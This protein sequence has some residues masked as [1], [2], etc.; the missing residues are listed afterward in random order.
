M[1]LGW[2][3]IV[4][5]AAVAS[6]GGDS[7]AT[8]VSPTPL[9]PAATAASAPAPAPAAAPAP[10]PTGFAIGLPIEPADSA[11]SAFG[12]APFGY[13]GGG[14]AE[15]GHPGWDVEYRA[16]GLVR[17]AADGV[18]QMVMPDAQAPRLFTIQI[19]H[20]TSGGRYRTNYTNIAAVAA[21]IAAGST[22]VAG[23]PIGAPAGLTQTLGRT[24]IAYYMIHFQLD[25]FSRNE[26]LT[27]PFA[28]SPETHLADSAREAFDAVWREAVF[29]QELV[30]PFPTNPRGAAFPMARVWTRVSGDL[31]ESVTFVR[32][33]PLGWDYDYAMADARGTTI[34]R[35]TLTIDI[36]STPPWVDLRPV[37]GGPQRRGVYDIVSG[38]MR[39]ALGAPGGARPGTLD[40]ASAYVTP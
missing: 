17:A 12:L 6:C 16:G 4:L 40:L 11:R 27:N 32:V 5:A 19:Q 24:S 10:A 38:T 15:D 21:G 1:R 22:V 25:D 35:G 20:A 33:Q 9:A 7:P 39:L 23:Q 34:E 3:G 37:G 26:G 2:C 28:V 31:A 8:P 36:A 30:E 14:H 29:G 13:H 18:I